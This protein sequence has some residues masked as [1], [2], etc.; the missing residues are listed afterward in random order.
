MYL[1]WSIEK[2]KHIDAELFKGLPFSAGLPLAAALP[3]GVPLHVIDEI[4]ELSGGVL[5]L[6]KAFPEDLVKFDAVELLLF[7]GPR[8]ELH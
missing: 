4:V 7:A 1:A 5:E 3:F 2:G 8:V 6:H